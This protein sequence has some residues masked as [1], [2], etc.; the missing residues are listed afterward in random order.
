MRKFQRS[1]VA[2]RQSLILQDCIM[3]M[4]KDVAFRVV[5]HVQLD[6]KLSLLKIDEYKWK[7]EFL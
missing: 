7:K 5:I 2:E 3:W 1:I 6:M 4:F